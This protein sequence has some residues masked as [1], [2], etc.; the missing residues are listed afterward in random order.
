MRNVVPQFRS[1]GLNGVA[2]IAITYIDTYIQ[3]SA[4]SKIHRM[5]TLSTENKEI[6][7]LICDASKYYS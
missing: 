3:T 1:W 6:V 7:L 4:E 2:T 5:C